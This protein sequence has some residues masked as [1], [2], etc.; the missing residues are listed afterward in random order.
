MTSMV[1][2]VGQFMRGKTQNTRTS[3]KTIGLSCLSASL[4]LIDSWQTINCTVS[5]LRLRCETAV[6]VMRSSSSKHDI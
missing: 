3:I 2:V 5:E 4:V 6:D 1:L